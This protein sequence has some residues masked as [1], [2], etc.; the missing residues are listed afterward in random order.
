[1]KT[2]V[3][4]DI[5]LYEIVLHFASALKSF[6]Y[7]IFTHQFVVA[8]R[9]DKCLYHE[10]MMDAFSLL[11]VGGHSKK[12]GNIADAEILSIEQGQCE[13]VVC[14]LYNSIKVSS[15]LHFTVHADV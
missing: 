2:H 1:M 6:S 7:R 12:L 5:K 14:S 11:T 15:S 8:I 4:S 9:R 3:A 13:E 10:T